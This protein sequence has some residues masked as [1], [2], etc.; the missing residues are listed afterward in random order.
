MTEQQISYAG[1]IAGGEAIDAL[2]EAADECLAEMQAETEFPPNC[3][4][5]QSV[6]WKCNCLER[7]AIA[8]EKK[9]RAR[10]AWEYIGKKLRADNA[11]I[12]AAKRNRRRA[13]AL[14]AR[15][16]GPRHSYVSSE[17]ETGDTAKTIPYEEQK[18]LEVEKHTET[19]VDGHC[20]CD[21]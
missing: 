16:L 17:E 2:L 8:F 21:L 1:K 9:Q 6:G 13:D 7:D 4:Y 18:V 3:I 11:R 15:E 5:C 20:V 14:R 12:M 10:R 19:C